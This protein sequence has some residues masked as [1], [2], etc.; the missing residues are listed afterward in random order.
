MLNL[1]WA[2][3]TLLRR[4]VE[5]LLSLATDSRYSSSG[6]TKALKSAFKEDSMLFNNNAGGAKVA[7]VGTTTEDSSTCIFTN[8]N[9]PETRPDQAGNAL[10][11]GNAEE[12]D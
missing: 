3:L 9:G 4:P 8:Y 2:S 7:I 1:P 10:I 11:S 5:L 6:I 12:L